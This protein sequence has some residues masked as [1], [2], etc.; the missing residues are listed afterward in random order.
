VSEA[1]H[2]R[3]PGWVTRAV[4]NPA[5]EAATRMGIGLWGSRV[6]ETTGRVSG[7]VRHTPVNLLVVEGREYLV[8]PRGEAQWVRNVR[9]G[10]GRLA[11]IRGRHR[12]ERVAS[13]LGD[14][15]KPPILRAYLRKWKMEIGVFF[16]GVDAGSSEEDVLRIAPKHPVFVLEDPGGARSS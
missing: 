3:K 7:K 16:D 9:A 8:S 6:L 12:Q 5:V 1:V 15:E 13:E 14:S 10:G 11:L 4:F 2:Y